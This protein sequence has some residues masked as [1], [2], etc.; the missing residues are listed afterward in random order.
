MAGKPGCRG[1]FLSSPG[2][3]GVV[4]R[5]PGKWNQECRQA[6]VMAQRQV[7]DVLAGRGLSRAGR[8]ERWSVEEGVENFLQ[9]IR[10]LG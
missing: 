4:G 2:P 8:A 7:T 5:G 9:A 3:H 1:V 6:A 10:R